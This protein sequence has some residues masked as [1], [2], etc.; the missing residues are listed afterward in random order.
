[1]YKS[2]LAFLEL[3]HHHCPPT[4]IHASL[5][6][7]LGQSTV[8]QI[9]ASWYCGFLLWSDAFT[10]GAWPKSALGRFDTIYVGFHRVDYG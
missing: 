10:V 6:R 4:P 2:A 7:S 8:Q 1:M 9:A 3:Q 5:C